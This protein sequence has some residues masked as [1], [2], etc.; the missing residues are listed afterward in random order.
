VEGEA[1]PTIMAGE[2]DPIGRERLRELVKTALWSTNLC[3]LFIRPQGGEPIRITQALLE[4]TG[5]LAELRERG[6]AERRRRALVR[7]RVTPESVREGEPV[8]LRSTRSMLPPAA[9]P[10]EPDVA[11][12]VPTEPTLVKHELDADGRLHTVYGRPRRGR[13][14]RVSADRGPVE[15]RRLA[16]NGSVHR[17]APVK[18]PIVTPSSNAHPQPVSVNREHRGHRELDYAAVYRDL[19]RSRA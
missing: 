18:A 1:T 16:T 5:V 15:A 12:Y 10:A 13:Y 19:V 6:L 17:S 11:E 14:V 9:R 2:V 8:C 3:P 4:R 7:N